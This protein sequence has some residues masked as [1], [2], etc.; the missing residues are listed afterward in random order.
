MTIDSNWW[1]KMYRKAFKRPLRPYFAIMVLI[2]KPRTKHLENNNNIMIGNPIMEIPN[3][4]IIEL[5]DILLVKL[6]NKD[7]V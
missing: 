6:F 3:N 5:K 1:G 4:Q 7:D 2:E